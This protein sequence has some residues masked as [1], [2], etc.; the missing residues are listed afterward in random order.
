MVRTMLFAFAS[1]I[2]VGTMVVMEVET[3]PRAVTRAG[4]PLPLSTIGAGGSHDTLTKADRLDV[5]YLRDF[6]YLRNDVLIQPSP[7]DQVISP[8]E[9]MPLVPQPARDVNG[10]HSRDPNIGKLAVVLPRPRPKNSTQHAAQS[11]AKMATKAAVK[12]MATKVPTDNTA[13]STKR[14]ATTDHSKFAVEAKPCQST[15]FGSL[16][17]VLNLSS[18]CQT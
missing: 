18:G 3:P 8:V 2:G 7:P 5:T 10:P 16:L 9:S 11:A 14:A 6:T 4:Q 1:L 12:K 13:K 15:T 17:K